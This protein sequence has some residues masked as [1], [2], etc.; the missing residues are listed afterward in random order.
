VG[1]YEPN[2]LGLFDMHGNV[3]EWCD[4]EVKNGEGASQRVSS[5]GSWYFAS[6]LCRAADSVPR[7]P[8]YRHDS[9]GLRLARVPA[10]APSP[11]AKTPPLA[12][13]PFTD[14]DVQ[15]IA[16]L[17]AAQ[18]VEEVRKEL[19]KRNPEFDGTL[20]SIDGP[21]P[22]IEDG[23]VIE[24][25]FDTD[26]VTDISP[27]RALTGLRRL[28]C[29]GSKLSIGT[30]SD[31]SPLKG[32]HFTDLYVANNRKLMDLSP[33]QGMPLTH[34]EV[35]GTS[36]ANIAVVKEMPISVLWIVDTPIADLSPLAGK[37]LEALFC[38]RCRV[39]TLKGLPAVGVEKLSCDLEQLPDEADMKRLG[40]KE[41]HLYGVSKTIDP[42]RLRALGPRLKQI[43]DKPAEEFLKEFEEQAASALHDT[44]LKAVA[45]LPL[46]QHAAALPA[47]LKE[48][49]SGFEDAML[50]TIPSLAADRQAIMV[51]AWLR[52]RNPAFEGEV[53]HKI[54]DG[55][56]T[57]LEVPSPLV[58]D[59]TPLRTLSGLR[60]LT[61]RS[62]LGYDNQAERDAALLRSLT[63]LETINGMPVDQFW[64]DA[65]V[66][67]AEFQEWLQLVPT[68]TA[69]QQVA[70]VVARLKERNPGLDGTAKHKIEGSVVTE[71][72]FTPVN[73]QDAVTDLSPVRA[74]AGLT[75]LNL[76]GC[77]GLGDL[78]P[79]KGLP[80]TRLLVGSFH[81]NTQVRDL[82]P[83]RGMKLAEL[84]LY[85][86]QV[87]DM[88]PLK[89]MPLTQL[90]LL[91]R[92]VRD[93]APLKGMP[94]T[95]LYLDTCTQIKDFTPLQGLPLT[96]LA[97]GQCQLKD[98]EVLKGMPLTMLTLA[99]T[100][101]QDLEPL[102][103][104]PL[105]VL[106]L[107]KTGVTDLKPLQGME[108]EEIRLTPKNIT[109]GL[110]ILRDV[111]SLKTIGIGTLSTQSWPAAEFWERYDQ[112][113][114]AK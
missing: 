60:T 79:L 4:D 61:G 48:R 17:P 40:V 86:C 29:N 6:E 36:V 62:T 64:K 74:L 9:R 99:E 88:E 95:V 26:K 98:L 2:R 25:R 55:V 18:Q 100:Q 112:G 92:Q 8:S 32:M 108:L 111:K 113:E 72:T 103:G 109:Q 73:G 21:E 66:R 76:W 46:D 90:T 43:N 80:L 28:K 77:S 85:H 44:W 106:R 30:L 58:Q 41:L 101:V 23:V 107:Y 75:S 52:D 59:L 114:F 57:S 89:G 97:L 96:G 110:E 42:A 5:S 78:E 65:E 70:A 67:Q 15:R 31:L 12:V 83:L 105:K 84:Q 82:E 45:L 54:E 49:L 11:E 1:A 87:R 10:G 50:R 71:L 7:A 37:S 102:R 3:W 81:V 20:R 39:T 22:K 68:L 14:A 63:K 38:M 104:M 19:K 51:A 94:L 91:S 53:T 24:L 16:A 33:L 35:W 56:L 69:P 27:V 47:K 13:G 34:L 93:C